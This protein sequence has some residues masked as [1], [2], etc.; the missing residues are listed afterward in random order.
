MLR[1]DTD[2]DVGFPVRIQ[3][4]LLASIEVGTGVDLAG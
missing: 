2:T 1:L 4:G 3:R